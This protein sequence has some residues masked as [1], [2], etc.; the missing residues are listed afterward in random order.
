L[1]GNTPPT[2][3]VHELSLDIA[4]LKVGIFCVNLEGS[5]QLAW[6]DFKTVLSFG[7]Q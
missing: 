4:F 6:D 3:F 7:A 1:E 2:P 5:R